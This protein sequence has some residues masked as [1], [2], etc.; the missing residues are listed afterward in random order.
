MTIPTRFRLFGDERRAEGLRGF[1]KK[2]LGDLSVLLGP[3]KYGRSQHTLTDG[4]IIECE[5]NHGLSWVTIHAQP[6]AQPTMEVLSLLIHARGTQATY[7]YDEFDIDPSSSYITLKPVEQA[8]YPRKGDYDNKTYSYIKIPNPRI[9]RVGVHEFKQVRYVRLSSNGDVEKAA[10]LNIF[11]D[12]VED[13]DGSTIFHVIEVVGERNIPNFGPYPIEKQASVV[14]TASLSEN[15]NS[16]YVVTSFCPLGGYPHLDT[17]VSF[18]RY[19]VF[20]G[21]WIQVGEI[22]TVDY[23]SDDLFW[24]DTTVDRNGN[25]S[26]FRSDISYVGVYERQSNLPASITEDNLAWDG[27]VERQDGYKQEVDYYGFNINTKS[28]STAKLTNSYTIAPIGSNW[29]YVTVT[30]DIDCASTYTY[31]ERSSRG[32][33]EY[34]PIYGIAK[35]FE[36]EGEYYK[37]DNGEYHRWMVGWHDYDYETFSGVLDNC[38]G[39]RVVENSLEGSTVLGFSE[40]SEYE[41]TKKIGNQ[42]DASTPSALVVVNDYSEESY[43]W[44]REQSGVDTSYNVGYYEGAATQD[45]EFIGRDSMSQGGGVV[46]E[47]SGV[48][49]RTDIVHPFTISGVTE[50]LNS[51]ISHDEETGL[52]FCG[53]KYSGSDHGDEYGRWRIGVASGGSRVLTDITSEVMEAFI[54]QLRTN[55]H[56]GKTEQLTDDQQERYFHDGFECIFFFKKIVKITDEDFQRLLM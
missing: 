19:I 37:I 21:E 3:L 15:L 47:N 53:V 5:L 28:F 55:I 10:S 26:T 41:Y 36:I 4:T 2:L 49:L 39:S 18:S 33:V 22:E 11:N 17:I 31:T 51:F 8:M 13:A 23:R 46:E 52:T 9:G 20:N 34:Y 27:L 44:T 48:V 16:L 1:G 43:D 50:V 35:H 56:Y 45:D 38:R 14:V 29:D 32:L 24:T 6:D 40:F 7:N 12:I 25:I 30:D 54:G 42:Y